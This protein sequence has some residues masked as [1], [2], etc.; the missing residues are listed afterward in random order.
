MLRQHYL[1]LSK[2]RADLSRNK[3]RQQIAGLF[4]E[5][6]FP[7]RNPLKSLELENSVV[8]VVHP[9]KSSLSVRNVNKKL[10]C[11]DNKIRQYKL[12]VAELSKENQV[13]QRR[14]T[15]AQQTGE[16]KRAAVHRMNEKVET[17]AI[18]KL[19]LVP[20]AGTRGAILSRG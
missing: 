14:L 9:A 15:S 20:V 16:K 13:L 6:F 18:E 5:P 3:Q 2:K 1:G 17:S 10:K 8:E 11:R 19:H 12:D 4:T 7:Q